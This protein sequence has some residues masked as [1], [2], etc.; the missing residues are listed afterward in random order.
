M[1]S[2]CLA[3]LLYPALA[4]S[5]I[6]VIGVEPK[7]MQLSRDLSKEVSESIAEV[8]RLVLEEVSWS[9]RYSAK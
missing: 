1:D 7:E 8:T 4:A 3:R 5:E 9:L 2:L 6:T